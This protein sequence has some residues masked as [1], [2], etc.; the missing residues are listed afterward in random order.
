MTRIFSLEE[1]RSSRKLKYLLGLGIIHYLS[2]GRERKEREGLEE[3][4][5]FQGGEISHLQKSNLGN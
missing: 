5:A 4:H 2:P 1:Y 3:S